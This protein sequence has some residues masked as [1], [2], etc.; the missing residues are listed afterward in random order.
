[1]EPP[2]THR[3]WRRSLEAEVEEIR[4]NSNACA[5]QGGLC[6]HQPDARKR[7]ICNYTQQWTRTCA[8]TNSPSPGDHQDADSLW[9]THAVA[10]RA[11]CG[12][13]GGEG[14]CGVVSCS[15]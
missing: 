5:Y 15:V 7:W 1:M 11:V 8:G 2:T 4:T 14:R 12:G 3:R 9:R 6:T 10:V 13:G